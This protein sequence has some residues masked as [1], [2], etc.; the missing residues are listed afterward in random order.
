MKDFRLTDWLP[1]TKKEME[2][3]GWDYVD[4]ILFS[5]DAYVD[6]PS[7][8]AAVIG[9][10]LEA[11][12]YRVAIVPQPDW[13]GDFR[14]FKKLGRPRL[15]FGVAPGCMDSMVNKYTANRRLR[16]EDAYSPDGRHD[17]RPEYPTIVYS[18]ILKRLYPDVP[19]ILGGIEAS[20]RR[21]THY[22][23]WQ[24]RSL[25]YLGKMYVDQIHEGEDYDK[26]KKCIHVGILDFTLFEHER[27]YSCFHI[28]EDTIR[29]M[30]SDKFEIHVLELPKLAKYEYP[31]TELLRWAQFFGARSREEIEVL[32]EKDEYIHKAYDKLEEISADEEKR[33]EYE[34]RQKA[35]RDHRHMLASGR[36][37]GLREGLREGKHEHAVEMARKMLEDKLPIEKIAEYSGL[38]PEDVH[39][40]EEQ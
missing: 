7:F 6:H 24:E 8:G 20:L 40:L 2:L 34:E 19:V 13:H 28:W 27:Y 33:L 25:F 21:L 35:I 22:D 10:V 18:Q 12:G 5:G 17:L 4:V 37:E 39:R 3:R 14:D 9:R 23:Y 30:Y 15:W 11:E 36:R 29:D 1:T 31:Q 38:S 26:L 32:A 16:S